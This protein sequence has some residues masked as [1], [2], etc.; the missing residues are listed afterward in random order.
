MLCIRCEFVSTCA[1]IFT[2]YCMTYTDL[3]LYWFFFADNHLF[4]FKWICHEVFSFCFNL[5]KRFVYLFVFSQK[6]LCVLL[7]I[8][9]MLYKFFFFF[10][11][12]FSVHFHFYVLIS[13]M[14]LN[15]YFSLQF[16]RLNLIHNITI[17][18]SLILF[19]ESVKYCCSISHCTNNEY[20]VYSCFISSNLSRIWGVRRKPRKLAKVFL[21]KKH[22]K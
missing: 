13:A 9:H 16:L 20:N 10:V 22:F 4:V 14:T 15:T 18:S 11:A 1:W 2:L 12:K 5:L 17:L 21:K 7:N 19:W 3:S 8:F 6:L